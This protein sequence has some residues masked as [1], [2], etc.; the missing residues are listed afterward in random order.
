MASACYVTRAQIRSG[1]DDVPGALADAEQAIER[2]RLDMDR[3]NLVWVLSAGMDV[4]S[5]HGDLER[6]ELLADEFLAGLRSHAYG[7][8]DAVVRAH[9]VAWT[10]ARLSRGQ[11]L[12]DALP[13][14]E[15]P[16]LRVAI[17]FTSGNLEAAADLCGAIGAATQEARDRLWLAKA[18][19][20][21]N[22]HA[23]ADIQLQRA[24]VFYR[25]VGATR[26]IRQAEALLAASV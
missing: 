11:E 16:W 3:Q 1:R 4:F 26:Y 15:T 25:S 18:L 20:E 24:L 5:E 10:L 7:L 12:I 9:N 17:L 19:L 23:K 22:R 6:A 8:G 14:A 13:H 2:A 21:Q